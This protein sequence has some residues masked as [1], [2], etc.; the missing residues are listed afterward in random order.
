M[1]WKL[2]T[3]NNTSKNVRESNNSD[4]TNSNDDLEGNDKFKEREMNKSSPP[5]STVI[6]NVDGSDISPT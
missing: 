1:S 5:F 4:Q 3:N 6:N 2:L